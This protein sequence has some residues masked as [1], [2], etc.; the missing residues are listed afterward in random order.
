MIRIYKDNDIKVVTQGVYKNLYQPLGYKIII[1]EKKEKAVIKEEPKVEEPK[2][3]T[4]IIKE[5]SKTNK[6]KRGE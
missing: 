3:K 4:V 6:R 2:E 1:E 5:S